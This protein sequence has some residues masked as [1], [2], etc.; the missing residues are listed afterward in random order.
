LT[1]LKKLRLRRV[2]SIDYNEISC[3]LNLEDIYLDCRTIYNAPVDGFPFSKLVSIDMNNLE[4]ITP[5]VF[6]K[7]I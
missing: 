1:Q 3:L 7:N 5:N 2:E 4:T 6:F